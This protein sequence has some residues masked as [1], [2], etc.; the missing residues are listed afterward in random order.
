MRLT[1]VGPWTV[2]II[3]LNLT[4][5]FPLWR[6]YWSSNSAFSDNA[7]PILNLCTEFYNDNKLRAYGVLQQ[8]IQRLKA[9]CS[10]CNVMNAV[11]GN[12]CWALSLNQFRRV[13]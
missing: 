6:T 4:D 1:W 13:A 12:H 11:L 5:I 9:W 8:L 10:D 3:R 2:D 7:Q